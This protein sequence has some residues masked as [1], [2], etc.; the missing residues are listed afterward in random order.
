MSIAEKFNRSG[1]SRFI[2][3]SSGRFFRLVAGA[4]F[5]VVGYLFRDTPLG[6]IAMVWSIIPLSAAAFDICYVSAILGGPLS[7]AKI[8]DAQRQ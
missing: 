2:N 7:G 6:V 5:L 8:R 4:G 3:S 1:F